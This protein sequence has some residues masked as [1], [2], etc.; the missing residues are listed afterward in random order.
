MRALGVLRYVAIRSQGGTTHHAFSPMAVTF[1]SALTGERAGTVPFTRLGRGTLLDVLGKG[2]YFFRFIMGSEEVGSDIVMHGD[3]SLVFVKQPVE[4]RVMFHDEI[5]G[6]IWRVCGIPLDA[7]GHWDATTPVSLRAKF[8]KG[9]T[10]VPTMTMSVFWQQWLQP[11]LEHADDE[12]DVKKKLAELISGDVMRVAQLRKRNIFQ[13]MHSP[14]CI[15]IYIYFSLDADDCL[16]LRLRAPHT[17]GAE[18]ETA[19]TRQVYH[20]LVLE[21]PLR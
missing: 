1:V 4:A 19:G 20:R 11:A 21:A 18:E 3:V 17:Y 5:S 13:E 7:L 9:N 10:V 8:L 15:D 2:A 6:C 12:A 16:N 14:H